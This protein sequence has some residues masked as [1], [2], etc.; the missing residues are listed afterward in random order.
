[1]ERKFLFDQVV[2]NY[3]KARPS[4][5]HQLI[6]DFLLA[7]QYSLPLNVLEIGSGAGQATDLLIQNNFNI[8]AV[9][10]GKN[11]CDFLEER[12][13]YYQKIRIFNMP[14]EEFES[15][16]KY[17][18]IFSASAFHWVDPDIGIKKAHQ[19]LKDDAYLLLCWNSKTDQSDSSDL[20]RSIAEQYEKYAPEMAKTNRTM[21]QH[22]KRCEDITKEQLFTHPL[23]LTYPYSRVMNSQQYIQLLSTYSDHIALE[24][25]KRIPLYHSISN[26]ILDHGDQITL[27]YEVK[28]YLSKKR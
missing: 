13:K 23:Y 22:E 20:F 28:T 19:L 6:D 15:N 21:F 24:D 18:L 4:Y 8:D 27:N 12:Y 26:I 3:A 5:P 11:M 2:E 9:E 14:F 7:S 1:M 16:M 10:L 17:D 25:S